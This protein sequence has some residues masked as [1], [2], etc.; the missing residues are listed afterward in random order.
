MKAKELLD[1][2]QLTAAID[3]LG[4][5]VKG[6]PAD[7][8][9][10]TFLFELLCFAGDFERARRQLDVLGTESAQAEAG[11]LMY[12][13]VLAAEEA[14]RRLFSDGL[15][16]TFLFAEPPY[17]HQHLEAVNR[18]RQDRVDE[19]AALLEKAEETRPA[20]SGRLNGEGFTDLRDADDVI[21]PFL[22]LF[23]QEQYVWLPIEQVSRIEI[24]AP[25]QLRDLLWIPAKVQG[26][27]GAVGEVFL[28]VLYPGSSAHED[29]Q[30]R[31]G[32]MTDW[33]SLGDGLARGSGQRMFFVGDE[34]RA[35][36]EIREIVF[37]APPIASDDHE[38]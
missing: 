6:H 19:A 25:K 12:R 29:E 1:Q 33:R 28:P 8:R 5:Q 34:E 23:L 13:T 17:V 24:A 3:D 31:L 11:T 2:G 27:P 7:F 15:R 14:R 4:R 22:E 38:Q 35:L 21:G 30:V 16:P 10:R 37:D 26:R 36:L 9:L 20:P 32:R 18:L